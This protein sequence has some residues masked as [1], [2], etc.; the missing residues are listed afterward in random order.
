MREKLIQILTD[1]NE[2]HNYTERKTADV[3]VAAFRCDG[4]KHWVKTAFLFKKCNNFNSTTTFNRPA[5][6]DF[7]CGKWEPKQ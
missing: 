6:A 2:V 5:D 1:A 4:C 7:F 3:I